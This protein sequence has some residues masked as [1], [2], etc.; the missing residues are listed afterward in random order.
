MFN[1]MDLL[2]KEMIEYSKNLHNR[3]KMVMVVICY[4]YDK[5]SFT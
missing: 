3:Y 5:Y 4:R 2:K 1:K